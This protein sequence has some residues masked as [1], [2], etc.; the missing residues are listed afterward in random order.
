MARTASTTPCTTIISGS[1]E[2]AIPG[3]RYHAAMARLWG[4]HGAA[5]RERGAAA[6]SI[7]R[8]TPT[9]CG[10]FLGELSAPM[11]SATQRRS[12]RTAS[13]RSRRGRVGGAAFR[14]WRAIRSSVEGQRPGRDGQ[15]RRRGAESRRSRGASALEPSLLTAE[16]ALAG[17]RGHS[18]TTMVPP[19]H[20]RAQVHICRR[21][22][23]PGV[24]EAMAASDGNRS[25]CARHKWRRL[26]VARRRTALSGERLR[27][28]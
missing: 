8:R 15:A 7:T 4:V 12:S 16:R 27:H 28:P 2:S 5:S 10:E 17:S 13:H 14:R 23:C 19:R 3:F 21:N 1:R 26:H 11:G 20:L 6:V 24:A 18:G 9:A 22:C 25:S